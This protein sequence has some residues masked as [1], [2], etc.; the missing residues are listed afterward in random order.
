MSAITKSGGSMPSAVSN[1]YSRRGASSLPRVNRSTPH[2]R[3]VAIPTTDHSTVEREYQRGL[4][5][6]RR[7]AWFDAH[8]AFETAWRACAAAERDFF[9]GLV[10]VVVSAYQA[11]RG[12]PVATERQRAKAHRRLAAFVPA[13]RGLD[14]AAVLA[15]LER[16]EADLRH[17]FVQ[18]RGE[19]P[20]AVEEEQQAEGDERRAARDAD[21][22]VV[23]A[24]PAERPH[25]V[26]EGDAGEDERGAEP[27]RVG[28]EQHDALRDRPARAREHEDR[29]EDGA[30]A[31]RGADGEGAPEYDR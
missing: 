15:A 14:V 16:P 29:G 1:R 2:N 26:R 7:A 17:Q 12:R 24:H 27:E 9:Q 22:P 6:A 23:V 11:G 20:A 25:G 18:R 21:D 30:D 4:A 10:H 5:L 8:E 28:D 13:H 31:G 3:I 19:P